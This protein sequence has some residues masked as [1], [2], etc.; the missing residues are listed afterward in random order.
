MK[1]QAIAMIPYLIVMILLFYGLPLMIKD[2]GSA[3]SVLLI[4]IPIGCFVTALIYGI[5]H[6]FNI[7]YVVLTILLFIPTISIFYNFTATVYAYIF[8]AITLIG[9][10]IGAGIHYLTYKK[11][12]DKK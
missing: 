10:G 11:P 4:G 3:M 2:T 1:K 7:V 12:T 8:G 6:A 5:R 9:N